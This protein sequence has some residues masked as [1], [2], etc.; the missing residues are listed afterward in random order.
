M[1]QHGES[2]VQNSVKAGLVDTAEQYPYGNTY[3][4]KKKR[5]G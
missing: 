3:L 4:T 1:L 2:F 5:R